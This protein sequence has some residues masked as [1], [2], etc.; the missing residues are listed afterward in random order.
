MSFLKGAQF[1][2]KQGRGA[3]FARS[4]HVPAASRA[5]LAAPL[6]SPDSPGRPATCNASLAQRSSQAPPVE[7]R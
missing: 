7:A 1:H 3:G 4:P 6:S 5:G 2:H